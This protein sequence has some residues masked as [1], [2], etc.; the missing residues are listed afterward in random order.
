LGGHR[1]A[2]TYTITVWRTLNLIPKTRRWTGEVRTHEIPKVTA[3]ELKVVAADS[4]RIGK[5]ST[6]SLQMLTPG[7]DVSWPSKLLLS[8]DDERVVPYFVKALETR[9]HSR[10]FDAC[11]LAK[12]PTDE[13]VAALDKALSTTGHDID[14]CTTFQIAETCARNVRIGA[15][16]SLKMNEDPRVREVVSARRQ[17]FN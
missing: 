8:I 17:D 11:T 12:Y 16:N 1:Q 3:T 13:A 7:I 2:G 4:K 5:S 6:A 9:S 14:N 15:F 10:K